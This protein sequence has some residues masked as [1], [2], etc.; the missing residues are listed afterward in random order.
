MRIVTRNIGPKKYFY[1]QHS[2]RRNGKVVTKEKYLG[3]EIPK[4]ADALMAAFRE[5]LHTDIHEQL[6]RIRKH[7]QKEWKS[8]P[9]SAQE[10]EL[11]QIAIAF[12][13]NTNAI[14]GSTITLEETREIIE[15]R[16]APNKPLSDV[17]E[18]EAHGRVFLRM[19][20]KKERITE[21]LLLR[22][23]QEVFGETKADLAGTYRDYLVR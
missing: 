4:N 2:F 16:I 11:E 7:F 6:N 10:K 1:L 19:L 5:E 14:E 21:A 9:P 20:S 13:Y 15:L 12:T 8:L 22:W 3:G 17:K 18:T 23:H